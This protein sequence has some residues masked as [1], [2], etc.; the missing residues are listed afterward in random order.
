MRFTGKAYLVCGWLIKSMELFDNLPNDVY[1]NWCSDERLILPD[2]S[3]NDMNEDV[4]YTWRVEFAGRLPKFISTD[5]FNKE[6]T[7]AEECKIK[8]F[9]QYFP[10]HAEEPQWMLVRREV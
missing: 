5:I 6:K 8:D 10:K 7:S 1:E 4:I 9:H 2:P 3:F